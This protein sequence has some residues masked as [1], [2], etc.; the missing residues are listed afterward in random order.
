MVSFLFWNVASRAN[1]PLIKALCN[2][3]QIDIAVLAELDSDPNALLLDLNLDVMQLFSETGGVTNR[4]RIFSRLPRNSVQPRYDSDK[5]SVRRVAP[6]VGKEV[7]F[8][9]VH[10]PSKLYMSDDEQTLEAVRTMREIE[11]AEEDAGHTRTILMGDLNMN[12]FD[13]GVVAADAFHAVMDKRIAQTGSRTVGGVAK[14]YFY[15]PMW[16]FFGNGAQGP[17]GTFFRKD[18]SH[19]CYFWY[20]FDQ[21]LLRPDVLGGFSDG[22]VKMVS[23]IGKTE[24]LRPNGR[25]N[26]VS[27]HLPIVPSVD[28]ERI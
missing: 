8:V 21:V 6:P 27:D 15:N 20:L 13:R 18:S 5:I 4:V 3:H 9:A 12:P 28:L 22:D 26:N 16:N 17:P 19:I 7:T 1:H 14:S 2:E 11:A 25:L 23:R 10:F 24:L